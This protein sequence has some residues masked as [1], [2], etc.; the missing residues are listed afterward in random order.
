MMAILLPIV[1]GAIVGF[2]IGL[3]GMGGG[4][5]MTPF[6]ILVMRVNPV[7]AV[8]TDLVFAAVTKLMGGIRH[9]RENHI[10]IS[11]VLWMAL[12][13]IPASILGAQFILQQAENRILVEKTLPTM[14]GFVLIAVSLT[15]LARA[16]RFLGPKDEVVEIRWPAPWALISIGAIGG[17]LVGMTSIGGGTVIMA[18]LLVFF[19]IPLNFMVGLDVLHG[20]L[21]AVVTSFNYAV[22]GQ[23]DWLLVGLLLTGSIPGAWL[24]ARLINRIDLR[25][26]RGILALLILLA[27]ID[28]LR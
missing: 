9:H 4:A 2:L 22:A 15:L 12:G 10:S 14:L 17:A 8:G 1:A 21:L 16:F 27:G 19:S 5:L 11:R 6:L 28:L 7:L 24:G 23:T 26:V 25:I 13:S 20:A 3:T 18:L